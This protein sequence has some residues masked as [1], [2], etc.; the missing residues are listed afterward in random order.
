MAAG[1][2]VNTL[3]PR[4][5]NE[6]Q[7]LAREDNSP[8]SLRAA[9]RQFEALF[10]QMMLK[11]MRDASPQNGPFDSEQTRMFQQ[12]HDQQLAMDLAQ[13]GGGMGLADAL[14]RQLGGERAKRDMAAPT[15]GPDGRMYFDLASVPRRAA[16]SAARREEAENVAAGAAANGTAGAERPA[17]GERA[18]ATAA[19]P[20][21]GSISERVAGFVGQVWNHAVEAGKTLG[22]PPAFIVAQAALETG[23]GRAELRHG[24]GR[25]SHNL[26]NIKA[27]RNWN[28]PVVE[29]PVTEYANGRAYTETARFRSYPSYAEAFR[30]YSRLLS[31]NSR[32]SEVLG[33]RDAQGFASALQRGGYATDPSYADKIVRI[34]GGERLREAINGLQGFGSLVSA[35]R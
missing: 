5:L 18:A 7:R 2:S 19:A 14:F 3:D 21:P 32:Y 11:A 6:L 27:G 16:I 17:A 24:D 15:A 23:W 12:M 34:V 13:G 8:E 35:L 22:V 29:L 33:Q 1:V 30:D 10:M 4:S 31:E 26:F 28:G 25:P 9:A 20:A